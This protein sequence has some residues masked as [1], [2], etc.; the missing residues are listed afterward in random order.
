MKNNVNEKLVSVEIWDNI[1]NTGW[2]EYDCPEDCTVQRYFDEVA[3]S[4]STIWATINNQ[5]DK[6]RLN[7][8]YVISEREM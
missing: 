7:G 5:D 4:E 3:F 1:G 2:Q 6:I 8:W